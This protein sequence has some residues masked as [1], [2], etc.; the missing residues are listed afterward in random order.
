MALVL[1]T[2]AKTVVAVVV[3]ITAVVPVDTSDSAS[4]C[5]LLTQSLCTVDVPVMEVDALAVLSI[6]IA[7]ATRNL[8][9]NQPVG[10]PPLAD[11]GVFDSH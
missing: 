10:W 3:R 5:E 9:E 7:V 2:R 6:M 11:K 1:A 4:D 8:S